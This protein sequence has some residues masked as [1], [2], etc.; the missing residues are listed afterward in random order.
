MEAETRVLRTE[1]TINAAPQTVWSIM[2]DL[3]RYPEWNRLLPRIEGRTTVG[4]K[5][6]ATISYPDLEPIPFS[7]TVTRIVGARELRWISTVP[8]NDGFTA[9]HY[10]AM[11]PTAAGG[12]HLENCEVFE[13]THLGMVWSLMETVGRKSFEDMNADLKAR[14]E[15]AKNAPVSLHPSVD[16][17]VGRGTV[18]PIELLRCG[19]K[20]DAVEAR[21]SGRVWHNHLCG[22]SKCWKPQRAL[23][24]QTAVVPAGTLKITANGGKLRIVDSTQAIQRHACRDCGTHMVGR[25]E[26]RDHH[27]YGLDFI[28]PELADGAALAPEFAGFVSSIIETGTNP[29]RMASVRARLAALGIPAFD[30]FSP[31]IMDIIAWH[32]MK[33]DSAR[34]T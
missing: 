5:L 2:D 1:I 34:R 9:D 10:F 27:F 30:V 14:A 29:T 11:T 21:V 33:I 22:C 28:H 26:D 16:N 25:V 20:H 13:G 4:Q 3:E 32:K 31:E 18:S 24:A 7:P 15:A 23:F 12:T 19:C 17:G 8:G 6:T